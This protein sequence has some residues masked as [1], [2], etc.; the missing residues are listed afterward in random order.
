MKKARIKV[1]EFGAYRLHQIEVEWTPKLEAAYVRLQ[2]LI[3]S[4]EAPVK[5]A[6]ESKFDW[7]ILTLILVAGLVIDWWAAGL[8][9]VAAVVGYTRIN[10]QAELLRNQHELQ[11]LR[12]RLVF[13]RD[14]THY[15]G[16]YPGTLE[17]NAPSDPY[18]L[19]RISAISDLRRDLESLGIDVGRPFE[20]IDDGA[21]D[22]SPEAIERIRQAQTE[23]HRYP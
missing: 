1:N 10:M 19:G 23:E 17:G 22:L 7:V 20:W 11:R 12:S 5:A 21:V 4:A 15:L 18:D 2:E 6:E 16:E 9:M 14:L 3:I 8:V 13:F